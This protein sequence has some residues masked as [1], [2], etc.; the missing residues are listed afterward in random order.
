MVFRRIVSFI[1]ASFGLVIIYAIW[2]SS[3][4]TILYNIVSSLVI[5][6]MSLFFVYVGVVGQG[7]VQHSFSDDVSLYKRIKKKYGIRW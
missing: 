2:D 1:G 7:W 4:D 3:S 5:L 6:T